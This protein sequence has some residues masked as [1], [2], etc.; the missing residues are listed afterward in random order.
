MLCL[1]REQWFDRREVL[2]LLGFKINKTKTKNLVTGLDL[3]T[4]ATN[5]KSSSGWYSI[6]LALH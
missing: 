2:I 5:Q 1:I 4:V 6:R 3:N